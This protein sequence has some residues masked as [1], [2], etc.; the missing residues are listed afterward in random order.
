LTF[1]SQLSFFGLGDD[2]IAQV[3]EE[4]FILKYHGG[5]SFFE[6]YNLPVAIRRWFIRRL[7]KQFKREKEAHDNANKKSSSSPSPSKSNIPRR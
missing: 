7:E 1:L 4:F 6:A 3:Y 5:W 2:Y